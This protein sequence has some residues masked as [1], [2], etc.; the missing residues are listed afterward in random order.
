MSYPY[1]IKSLEQYHQA[2]KQSIENPENFWNDIASHFRW[3][4]K[5]NSVLNWNFNEPKTEWFQGGKLNITENC[6]D[7]WAETQPDATAIIWESNN[8][9]ENHR[10]IS[11]K[12]LLERVNQFAH[13]LKNN[14]AKKGDRIC[15]YM[16]MV[17]ELAIAVLACARIGAIHS[18]VFGGFSAQSIADRINDAQCNIV[19][20]A[21]GG[22]RGNKEINLKPIIDDALMQCNSVKKVIVLTRTRTPISMMNGRDI[23]WEDEIK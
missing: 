23:W 12:E 5:Y 21:D 9:N 3:K 17:P 22:F 20:T 16:P 13:V 7:R 19:I 10:T 1:Q 11:Y 18:V 6:L 15:I 2:Y 8:P 14:G 4:K